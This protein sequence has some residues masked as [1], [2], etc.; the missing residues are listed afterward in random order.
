M[1]FVKLIVN[2]VIENG[3]IDKEV[4][5]EHPFNKFGNVVNLFEDKLEIARR[6]IK[7]ID[8]LNSRLGVS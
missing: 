3:T 8:E 4:L 6:I 7:R 5:N 2:Y 1:E